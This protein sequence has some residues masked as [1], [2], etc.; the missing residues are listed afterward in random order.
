[1]F[2]KEAVQQ[3]SLISFA[4]VSQLKIVIYLTIL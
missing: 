2:Q 3:N 1:M 4:M